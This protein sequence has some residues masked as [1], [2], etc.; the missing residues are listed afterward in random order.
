M[1]QAEADDGI[2]E[3]KVLQEI[4]ANGFLLKSYSCFLKAYF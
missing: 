3:L 4:F 1:E 2:G